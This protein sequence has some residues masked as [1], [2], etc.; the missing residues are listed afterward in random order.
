MLEYSEHNAVICLLLIV[1][2]IIH[3]FHDCVPL[4]AN[5]NI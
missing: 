3:D 1:V 4:Y 5:F 2:I